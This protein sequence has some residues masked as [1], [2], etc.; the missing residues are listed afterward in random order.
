MKKILIIDDESIVRESLRMLLKQTY[1]LQFAMDGKEGIN[2]YTESSPDLVLLDIAMPTMDGMATL[3]KLREIDPEIPIIMLTA[4]F[5]TK[6][7]VSAMK[8]GAKDYI[9]K[10]FDQDELRLVIEREL[11][12]RALKKEVLHLRAVVTNCYGIENMVG[13][14]PKINEIF[15]KIKHLSGTNA[16]ILITGESGTGKEL[17]ARALHLNSLRKHGPF[18]TINCAAIPE[19]LIES[20]LF[21]HERGAFTDAQ[22]RRIGHFE[23]ADKGTFFMDE[24]AD[25]S[26]SCQAKILRAVQEKRFTRIGGTQVVE[27]DVRL[28]TATNKDLSAEM[29]AGRFREDLY[30]RVN[31]IPIE[32]PPLRERKGDIPLL[33]KHFLDKKREEKESPPKTISQRAVDL[34][35]EYLWPG[36]IRELENMIEQTL[37]LSTGSHIDE[38]DLPAKIRQEAGTR[39]T[40]RPEEIRS[41]TGEGQ[42]SQVQSLTEAV[43]T[44]E[45]KLICDALKISGYVQ[46]KTARALGISRR[47]LKY[48]MNALGIP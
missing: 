30:Y 26:L 19:S 12:S 38:E 48:K 21:G 40:F 45:K 32:L 28:I 43:N 13:N 20:E 9:T 18:V 5:A 22:T 33:V 11:R 4:T 17:V 35:S 10:P 46:T 16:P 14:S 39:I 44:L 29:R 25:L 8:A 24:V 37:A 23:Q 3:K 34:L 6:T 47:I 7:A 27:T 36:N 31:V 1:S 2:R 41:N 42:G 15:S